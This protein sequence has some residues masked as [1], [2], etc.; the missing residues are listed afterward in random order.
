AALSLPGRR[1]R[2]HHQRDADGRTRLRPDVVARRHDDRPEHRGHPVDALRLRLVARHGRGPDI[3]GQS[4]T[5]S[6][7][8]NV[9]LAAAPA[10]PVITTIPVTGATFSVPYT[11]PITDSAA[12]IRRLVYDWLT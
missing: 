5:Q 8:I 6:F 10:P 3:M 11:Q 2:G 9:A 12:N 1:D 7:A 4:A